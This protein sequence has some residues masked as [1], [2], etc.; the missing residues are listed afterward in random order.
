MSA[1]VPTFEPH[2]IKTVR[3]IPFPSFEAR[4]KALAAANF[5]VFHL[6]ASAVS[7]DM[8]A[9]G[10]AAMSQEQLAGQL[11]G[12][13]AYAGSRNFETLEQAVNQVLGHSY[14]CPTHNVLGS[15]KLLCATIAPAGST[16]ICNGSARSELLTA[17]GVEPMDVR[18][19]VGTFAGDVDLVRIE[20][21]VKARRPALLLLQAFS[22]GMHPMSLQNLTAVR[23]FADG[24]G[25]RL[26]LDASRLV[27]NAWYI[28]THEAGQGDRSVAELVKQ[29]AK[30]AHVVMLDGA[31]DAKAN[32]GGLL[33]TDNPADYER[34][35]NEVVLY[36]G[37]HTYGGMSGRTMELLARGLV[38]MVEEAEVQWIMHQTEIFTARLR[39]AGIPMERG[40]DGAYLLADEFL[41]GI[42]VYPE[43]ALAAALYQT[44][45]IRAVPT[46]RVGRDHLVPVQIPRLAMTSRQ[47]EEIAAAVIHLFEQREKVA[48]LEPMGD[49]AWH[50]ELN[51][52][53]VFADLANRDASG[54][55]PFL[56]HTVERVGWLERAQRE[57][58]IREAGWNTFLL[59]SADVTID[60][61]TDSG[62]SAMST[63]QWAAYDAARAT[64]G[65]TEAYE[66]FLDAVREAYGYQHIIPT[67]QGRAAE[68]I[69][70][71]SR[72]RPGQLV[73]GNMYFTTTKVHQEKAGGTFVDIIVDE[74]HKPESE[75]PW[76]GNI[77]MAKLRAVVDT[78]G[79]DKVAY[80][81][82]E[83]SVNMAGGQ[84][85]SMDNMREVYAYC[86]HLGIPVYFD[87]T[88]SVE[89]A[90]MIQKKD[91]RY[92]GVAVKDIL[93]E[94][95][96][97]GDGCTVSGKKDYL[98]NIG[99]LLAFKDDAAAKK[100][101]EELLRINEG[102][103][104]DGGLAAGDLAAM[105]R[106]INEMLD[107][108]YIASRVEQTERLGRML[109][110][111]GIPIVTPPGTHAIF[112]DAKRFL[113]HID[114]DEFP[115]QRLAAELYIECG[116]RAME[117][118]N[119]SKGR[120]RATGENCRPA[121]ELV[122]LTIPR[123][124]YTNDHMKAVAE[125]V[126]RV[127]ARR[128]EIT[129][130]RFVYEPQDLR[131]FQARFEPVG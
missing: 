18:A 36:E 24:A 68:H 52:R 123:R 97:Y 98:I 50:D 100:K 119:V 64:A 31:Q 49:A 14:V 116:V 15:V 71:Q 20:A 87:S 28:Q 89:N 5:N 111:A 106:G 114:Q 22:D 61:L 84:P 29:M 47:L 33:T 48:V 76:K 104:T 11:I 83:H 57:K 127:W 95:M 41:P 34:F 69:L 121:L 79:A 72:I 60:L 32:T 113:P 82:F 54:G 117:R 91:P 107:D 62:T 30:L 125:G 63:D 4:K 78:H 65:R 86:S 26:V 109:M 3:L 96:A 25:L 92:R 43:H 112:V 93:R 12:D 44:T 8:S 39:A 27:E 70:S 115:A 128:A 55:Y 130:L 108:R 120:D 9:L 6:P 118:G 21:V 38:E 103:V 17:R 73:P 13:E 77:D 74:A 90:Y 58:A 10:T 46:G 105:A 122:R 80:I 99:G 23:R 59:R 35:M 40:C 53:S 85:V 124:V 126:M 56:I 129:G 81:S 110:D 7:Y 94:M 131:F 102:R 88:R 51:F 66:A 19:G 1:R 16:V 101:A 2:K 37:L 75:F 45:G 42:S 67:H